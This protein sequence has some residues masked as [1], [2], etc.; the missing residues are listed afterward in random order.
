MKVRRAA[1]ADQFYEADPVLLKK[2]L[3]D[4]FLHPLGPGRLPP[5]PAQDY[6]KIFGLVSPHAGYIYSGPVAAH[7]YYACSLLSVDLVVIIGPNH[8]GL[9]SG[10]AALDGGL[11]RS[12]LG[13]VE[14]DAVAA[15]EASKESG[16]LDFSDEAHRLEHSVEVQVPFLQYALQGGFRILPISLIMQDKETAIELGEALAHSLMGRRVLFVASSDLT[17]Y[18]EHGRASAKD[19]ELIK[20]I[21]ELDIDKHYEVL[22]RLG[23]SAC[24]YGAI[25]AVMAAVKKMGA[26]KGGLLKYATSGDISQDYS[27][28]VGYASILLS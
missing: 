25:A 17:H 14:V 15:K 28:V 1:V 6:V 8:Y 13:D 7:G 10:V 16:L 26:K 27:S 22:Q 23:V 9:G 20:A 4:C 3:Q 19:S 5:A 2:S 11:W 21:L 18:E 24:G 12:P